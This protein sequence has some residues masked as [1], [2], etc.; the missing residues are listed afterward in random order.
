LE[1]HII[2]VFKAEEQAK[3]ETKRRRKQAEVL[4]TVLFIVTVARTSHLL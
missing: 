4:K 1:E 2:S 3:Q